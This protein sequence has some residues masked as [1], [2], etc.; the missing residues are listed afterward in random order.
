MVS[1]CACLFFI[2]IS[3]WNPPLADFFYDTPYIPILFV[4]LC[5][6]CDYD[7]KYFNLQS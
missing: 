2:I 6:L 7:Y 5:F 3:L 4:I 1:L